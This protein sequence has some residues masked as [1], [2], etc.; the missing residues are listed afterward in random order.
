MGIPKRIFNF[1][2]QTSGGTAW[3]GISGQAASVEGFCALVY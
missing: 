3:P 1:E 2:G